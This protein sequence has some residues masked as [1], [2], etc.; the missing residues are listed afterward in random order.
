MYTPVFSLA[1]LRKPGSFQPETLDELATPGLL[2]FMTL[3]GPLD[4]MKALDL[5]VLAV[6]HVARK[7]GGVIC[8]EHRHKLTN[9]GLLNLRDRVAKLERAAR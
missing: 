9:Q 4:G 6:D 5:L 7:L 8:D 1:H 2:V 3:P